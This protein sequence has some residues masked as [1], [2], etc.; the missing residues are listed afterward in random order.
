MPMLRTTV[1]ML[2]LGALVLTGCSAVTNKAATSSATTTAQSPVATPRTEAVT[3]E[4]VPPPSN[5]KVVP[6]RE[7]SLAIE[8]RGDLG[9]IV[10]D[11]TGR[12]LYAFTADGPNEPT[13]YGACAD[14][15][16][17]L[18]ARGDPAGTIGIDVASVDVVPRRDGGDQVTYNRIP[19]YRYAGDTGDRVANGQGL[20]M[21]GGE[22]HVLAK[23][24]Q[25]LA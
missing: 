23:D 5:T 24:G 16:V 19:L 3:P 20:D 9:E 11:S 15:W 22:W 17:P 2:A 12:A 13:C 7:V 18:L 6:T 25:P 4:P 10:V 8:D 1:S 14:T 21:F